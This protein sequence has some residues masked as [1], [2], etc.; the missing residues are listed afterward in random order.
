VAE[1]A[2]VNVQGDGGARPLHAAAQ[3]GHVDAVR[4]LVE[5]GAEVDASD[6]DGSLHIAAWRG[7]SAVVKTLVELGLTR[8][9]LVLTERDR[10]M[11]MA[12]LQGHVAVVTTLVE[13]GADIGALNGSGEMHASP[14]Q[15]PQR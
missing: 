7:H 11:H 2:G 1:G 6:A 9:Q 14:G 15:H 4:V 5:V 13:L 12:A 8:R 10:C 3:H